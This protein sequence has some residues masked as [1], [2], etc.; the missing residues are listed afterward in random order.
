MP[1]SKIILIL[2]ILILLAIA[3]LIIILFTYKSELTSLDL[4]RHIKNGEVVW[5]NPSVLYTN[6]YS[7]TEPDFPFVNHHWLSGAVYYGLY[8]LGG[9]NLITIINV[10]LALSIVGVAFWHA[11]KRS[12]FWIA[13]IIALPVVLIMSERTDVRPEMFSYLFLAIEF[14]LLDQWRRGKNNKYLYWLIPIQLLWSNLHIYFFLG[15]FLISVVLVEQFILS[16]SKGKIKKLLFYPKI[17]KTPLNSIS[18]T[19]FARIP[20]LRGGRGGLKPQLTLLYIT[21]GSYFVSI[22]NPHHIKGLL[23]PF[24]ILKKY[25][26]E[27]AENKSPLFL[28]NLTINYNITFFKILVGIL[29]ISFILSIWAKRK[30]KIFE[31]ALAIFFTFLAFFAIR[32]LAM[33]AFLMLPIISLNFWDIKDNT[34]LIRVV[35]DKYKK[36]ISN[37]IIPLV[38]VIYIITIGLLISDLN[39]ERYYLKHDFGLGIATGNQD[40]IHF[41]K[42]NNL[43]G[44]IFNNYDIGSALAFWLYPDEKVFV[45]NRPEA[46]SVN[47]FNDIYKPMQQDDAKW[48]YFS[49]KYNLNT[50]YFR[51]TD[52]TPWAQ[53]FLYAR[54]QDK[55]WPLIYFDR[56]T[57]IMVKNIDDNK[58]VINKYQIDKNK[59]EKR[60]NELAINADNQTLISLG[61]LASMYGNTNLTKKLYTKILEQYSDYGPG[62]AAMGYLLSGNQTPS[63]LKKSNQYLNKAISAG[64]ELPTIYNQ[65]GLNYWGM[66]NWSNAEMMWQKAL[67]L[68]RKNSHAIYYLDQLNELREAKKIP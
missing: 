53:Q 29:I 8:L 50:I 62:L 39:N 59:F 16:I 44:P 58:D 26:Y 43:K 6:F 49:N 42:K 30:V 25:G 67:K 68:D 63:S 61:T 28:E 64:Y 55:E 19:I 46:Y 36:L 23:Y 47:F 31:L 17:D 20:L 12:N 11:Q 10:L 14:Y 37:S 21:I 22:I 66:K 3:S 51:H 33:F 2:K 45:D 1:K 41:Y 27:I 15:L 35:S 54:L 5:Q 24:N 32:N 9:F 57:L 48:Q 34:L 4:G 18:K 7:Y 38:L 56:N 13:S 40:S 60:I 65:I 52:G